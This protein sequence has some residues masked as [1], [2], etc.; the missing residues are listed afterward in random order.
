MQF[1]SFGLIIWGSLVQWIQSRHGT[2]P[3]CRFPFLDVRP[4][5]DSDD[6]SSDGGEYVPDYEHDLEYDTDGDMDWDYDEDM[7]IERE[8]ME[9]DA[10]ERDHLHDYEPGSVG[11]GEGDYE[12]GSVGHYAGLLIGESQAEDEERDEGRMMGAAV[13]LVMAMDAYDSSSDE[14]EEDLLEGEIRS[15]GELFYSE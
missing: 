5:S 4:P 2:C 3:T 13:G 1:G 8:M 7:D 14:S 9:L 10:D 15:T 11:E 12:P 6:E